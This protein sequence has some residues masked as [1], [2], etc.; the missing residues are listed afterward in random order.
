VISAGS[1]LNH[2][3][4]L[5]SK[6]VD[7]Q[8]LA[9]SYNETDVRRA[10][11]A[12][13]YCLFHAIIEDSAIYLV[14]SGNLELVARVRRAFDHAPMKKACVAVRDW[15][16]GSQGASWTNLFRSEPDPKLREVARAFVYLQDQRHLADYD[17]TRDMPW[18]EGAR[19]CQEAGVAWKWWKDVQGTPDIDVFH[20]A[21]LLGDRLNRHG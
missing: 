6:D 19:C 18:A 5:L 21:L 13:Y 17:L 7:D 8:G 14:P 4:S 10:I 20:T 15:K 3:W 9:R 16:P 1:Y 12:A 11:S 2:A